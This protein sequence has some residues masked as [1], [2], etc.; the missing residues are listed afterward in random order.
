MRKRPNWR[1]RRTQAER[2]FFRSFGRKHI[3][4]EQQIKEL[5]DPVKLTDLDT[6][7]IFQTRISM[8]RDS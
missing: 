4:T 8:S 1:Q 5:L 3:L 7:K 6:S 2:G